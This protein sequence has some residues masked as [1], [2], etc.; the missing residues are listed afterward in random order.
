MNA[1]ILL[2]MVVL[3]AAA[4]AYALPGNVSMTYSLR[5]DDTALGAGVET[6]RSDGKSYSI[7]SVAT[8]EGIYRL[9]FGNI[10]R[11]SRG[12]ITSD[13]LK[14]N[15]F[16]DVR[17]D[18]TYATA[19]FDWSGMT[20][21]LSYKDRNKTLPLTPDAQD[22][23]SFA[24][25]FAFDEKLPASLDVHLTN[26]KRL[27]L[28]RYENLGRETLKTPM[29]ALETVHLKR[30]AEPGKSVSEIWLSVAHHHLPV[31]VVITDDDDGS[32]FE[33]S[34]TAIAFK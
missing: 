32:R 25:S 31:K 2:L 13:G 21:S 17:N 1:N 12:A 22:H 15:V 11:S 4:P 34:V 5:Q 7:E 8:G 27:S 16:E 14:P 18:K 24:Y 33:Q 30:K 6:W 10:K 3:A 19:L 20:L 29:G 23:L 26:G 28:Y 9:L